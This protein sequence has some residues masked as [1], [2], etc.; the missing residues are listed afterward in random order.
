[1]TKSESANPIKDLCEKY[2]ITQAEFSRRFEIPLRSI[3]D[4]IAGRRKPPVYVVNMLK[5]LL[6]YE[7][8]KK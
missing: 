8:K 2:N 1:M 7:E 3:E 5:R 4:W 6:E